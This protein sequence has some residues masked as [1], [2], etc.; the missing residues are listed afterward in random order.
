MLTTST[1]IARIAAPIASRQ[2]HRSAIQLA[3]NDKSTIDSYRFPSQTSINEWEFKYDFVP[4]TSEPKIP[5]LT[6]EA[7]KQDIAQQKKAKVEKELLDKELATSVKVEANDSTVVHGGEEVG[8]EPEYLHDR[9][10]EP[11]DV[12]YT[13]AGGSKTSKP[14]NRDKYVQTSINPEINQSDVVSLSHGEVDHKA[15]ATGAQSQVLEDVEHE[16][17]EKT[18]QEPQPKTTNYFVP[19]IAAGL[20]YFGYDYYQKQQAKK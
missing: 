20:G 13:N 15:T 3:K 12:S 4:K 1:R 9:G 2:L 6:P 10:S 7:V 5:P 8:A 17:Y 18:K 14:A 16:D 11:A 19:L